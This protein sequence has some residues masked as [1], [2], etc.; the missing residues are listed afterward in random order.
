M[1]RPAGDAG[2]DEQRRKHGGR[3]AAEVIGAG[4]V[5]IQVRKHLL[6]A[7]HDL[8]EA[9]GNRKEAVIA[10]CLA[11]LFRPSLDDI[12]ARVGD[13]VNA[14]AEAH[15]ELFGGQHVH[16]SFFRLV[17]RCELL[18]QLHGRFVG[19][20]MQRPAQRADAAGDRRIEIGQGRNDGPRR[21]RRGVELMLGVKNQRY[22]DGA[23]VQLVGLFA[24]EQMQ[25]V[26]GGAVVVG[27]GIDA[28]AVF[29]KLVPVEKHRAEASG[30][31]I[32]D[33]DLIV[34][35]PFGLERAEHRAAGAHHI[36]RM[37][38]ARNKLENSFQRPAASR[39]ARAASP[40]I[41]RARLAWASARK[42]AN[43][44]LLRMS[45][46]PPVHGSSSRDR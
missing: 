12:R 4:A 45:N 40:C 17:G 28:R 36:H 20:A 2:N 23:A 38:A 26:A 8:F 19:A 44:R 9:L 39:A 22:V 11:E 34:A 16:Q 21:E 27:F 13:F 15:D 18:D 10:I 31:T 6:F 41:R 42:S 24:V 33:G 5:K 43:R 7:P 46:V 37:G 35:G 25:Q 29:M 32:G 1:R 14:M 3:D 30:K